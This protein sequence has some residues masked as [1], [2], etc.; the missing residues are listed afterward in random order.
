MNFGIIGCGKAAQK[1]AEQI[2][3]SGKL[4]AVCDIDHSKANALGKKYQAQPYYNID[5]LLSREKS[6]NVFAVCT[7]NYLHKEHTVACLRHGGHVVCEKPMAIHIS[8][9]KAMIA[10]AESKGKELFIVKQ[11]RFN[12]AVIA[13]KELLNKKKIGTIYSVHVNCIWNR[14]DEYY[15]NSWRG[16]KML[17][18]GILFTQFS[19]FIDLLYW[20]FGE[21]E[22]VTAITSNLAHQKTIEFEDT[23]VACLKFESGTLGSIHF[24]INSYKKNMEGSLTIIAEKGTI[25]IGGE[26]LNKLEYQ[27]IENY[28]IEKLSTGNG[29]NDYGFYTGSMS[30][31]NL[32]YRHVNDVLQKGI[33]NEFNGYYGLKT[34][35]IIEKIYEAANAPRF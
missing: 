28:T 30:N 22:Y 8:D 17:D 18:G 34:V 5:D 7:P 3:L 12:P 15:F 2:S 29:E 6:I 4:I 1:H 24:S 23:G 27:Q 31:H 9:C 25:K 16:K 20:M 10:E 11:N 35:E 32:I 19:H 33:K 21:V 26:Y 14:N 13:V